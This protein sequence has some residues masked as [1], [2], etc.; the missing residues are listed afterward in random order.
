[1]TIRFAYE[2][3]V[4]GYPG[5]E[6]G[7]KLFGIATSAEEAS[8]AAKRYAEDKGLVNDDAHVV[9]LKLVGEIDFDTDKP[10]EDA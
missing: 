8:A 9:G 5:R 7:A 1:M 10:E 2:V 4:A 3:E 6:G